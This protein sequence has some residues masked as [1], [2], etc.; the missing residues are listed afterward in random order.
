MSNLDPSIIPLDKGLNLQTAKLLAPSGSALD[1]INYEQVDF[2]GQKRIDGYTRYDGSKLSALD[3]YYVIETNTIAAEVYDL[4]STED[5]TAGLIGVVV[6][7]EADRYY[8]AVINENLLPVEGDTFYVLAAGAPTS[9]AVA[10]DCYYG[11]D[12]VGITPDT[13]Y[14]RLIALNEVLRTNVESLPGRIAG[15]HWFRDRLY[16]VADVVSIVLLLE[17]D[18]TLFPNDTITSDEGGTAKVLDAF[19]GPE[20]GQLYVYIATMRPDQWIAGATVSGPS[21]PTVGVIANLPD[22]PGLRQYASFFESRSEQQVLDEDGPSGPYDF[23][24]RFVDLGWAVN[25]ELGTS[26]F[27]SLPSLN[28]NISGLGIEGPTSTTGDNG[29]PL[30][31]VQKIDI[32]NGQTQVN[33]WKSSNTPSSYNLDPN[34]LRDVDSFYIYGDAFISWTAEGVVSAPG[35]NQIGMTEYAPTSTIVVDI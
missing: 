10:G 34:N 20:E 31:L 4:L 15:L 21:S 5:G 24:W 1:G 6:G 23:G 11:V 13:H 26:L 17:D 32:N 27:G 14:L 28:Q 19:E 7:V 29:R 22:A 12:T 33:G 9:P 35:S 25:F 2:Q 3:D 8:V 18:D 30:A 16:A